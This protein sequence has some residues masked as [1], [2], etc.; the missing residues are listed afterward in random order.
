MSGNFQHDRGGTK[1]KVRRGKTSSASPTTSRRK[2]RFRKGIEEFLRL[3]Q[4]IGTLDEYG[5]RV[6]GGVRI[7]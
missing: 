3:Y 4:S 5:D 7:C 1:R 2:A 6:I